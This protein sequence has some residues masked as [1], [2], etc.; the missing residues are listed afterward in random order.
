ML[1]SVSIHS[2]ELTLYDL[3]TYLI[4]SKKS[5][6]DGWDGLKITRGKRC[7]ECCTLEFPDEYGLKSKEQFYKLINLMRSTPILEH[8][9]KDC[10]FPVYE[11]AAN[12]LLHLAIDKN[13]ELSAS[14]LISPNS[15]EFLHLGNKGHFAEEYTGNY[16]LKVINNYK[17]ID[18]IINLSVIHDFISND[19]F[20]RDMVEIGLIDENEF[21]KALNRLKTVQN[22]K[23]SRTI[24]WGCKQSSNNRVN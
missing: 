21:N 14:T 9:T 20:I 8:D 16:Y 13:H 2:Q 18:S 11:Y 6:L 12:Q 1:I 4:P 17:D 5:E 22:G 19:C 3:Q 10:W 24:Q 23:F 7:N 15:H